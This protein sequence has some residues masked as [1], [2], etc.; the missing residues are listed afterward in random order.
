VHVS[1]PFHT[2]NLD[3]YIA[4]AGK[5]PDSRDRLQ[6]DLEGIRSLYRTGFGSRGGEFTKR[7]QSA[8]AIVAALEE[9]KRL[10]VG[11][12]IWISLWRWRFV[13]DDLIAGVREQVPDEELTSA[14][15]VAEGSVFEALVLHL[16]V[17]FEQRFGRKAGYTRSSYGGGITGP[18]MDFADAVLDDWGIPRAREH[19]AQTLTKVRGKFSK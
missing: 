19:I 17:V 13:L 8:D 4:A 2:I 12:Y 18:F 10:I 14:V 11:D 7:K 3:R 16:S 5:E 9:A 6:S 1:D 15:G